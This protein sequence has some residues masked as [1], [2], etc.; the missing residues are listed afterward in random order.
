MLLANCYSLCC[1][2][3]CI[4]V[5]ISYSL[6]V[7]RRKEKTMILIPDLDGLKLLSYYGEYRES[8]A[9]LKLSQSK[10]STLH[11]FLGR[12]KG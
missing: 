12:M 1:L 4:Q 9:Y 6:E 7:E 2:K 10:V 8:K 5:V 3:D 11:P